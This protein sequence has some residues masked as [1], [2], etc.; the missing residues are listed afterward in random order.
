MENYDRI[1]RETRKMYDS[2]KGEYRPTGIHTHPIVNLV[3]DT[4]SRFPS[5]NDLMNLLSSEKKAEVIAQ[6]DSKTGRLQGYTVL[7]K[8]KKTY[9]AVYPK[10]Y[11][12]RSTLYQTLF[13][14]GLWK[15]DPHRIPSGDYKML[16]YGK[17]IFKAE[18]AKNIRYIE[19]GL[20]RFCKE[21]NI[22]YK[23]IEAKGKEGNHAKRLG[24]LE[25]ETLTAS[26]LLI[27]SSLI[28][29]TIKSTGYV[30]SNSAVDG[31]SLTGL[32]L[33]ALGL[34]GL[35]FSKISKK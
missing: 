1:E 34:L 6:I 27:F 20:D 18:F 3:S 25:R 22:Q 12:C 4:L 35:I 11:K 14:I 13:N 16:Q 31:Y 8:T 28:F 30:V 23:F 10:D 17:S 19:E 26:I 2:V 24:N 9:P 5:S 15:P 7:R 21:N 29:T 32:V 33:L